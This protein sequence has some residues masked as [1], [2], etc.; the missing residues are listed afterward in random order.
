MTG[1]AF[2]D[3]FS[4][5]APSYAAARPRYPA[6][7]YAWVAS[8][9]PSHDR[10]WD[11]AT[12]N[13]Q[14]ALGLADHFAAVVATD[15]SASQIASAF[16]HPRVEYRV[17]AVEDSGLAAGSVAVATFAQAA[18]W[19]DHPRWHAEIR[20][21]LAPGGAVVAWCYSGVRVGADLDPWLDDLSFG[22]LGPYWPPERWLVDDGYRELA[23]PFEPIASPG[24]AMAARWDRAALLAYIATWSSV[25]RWR[26]A[27]GTDPVADFAAEAARRWPDGEIREVRWPLAV[28]AGRVGSDA[29]L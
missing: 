15:A 11:G 7:L 2:K 3:H 29:G 8:I 23:F 19:F 28:R 5:A 24:F 18:H 12:G 13:G 26:Q 27:H 21:V 9:A 6:E 22:R 1:T 25:A 20:R 17:A 10:A 14:A 4:H 16:P